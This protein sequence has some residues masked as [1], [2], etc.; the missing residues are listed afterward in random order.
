M[1]R[2][3]WTGTDGQLYAGD[4]HE[5]Q[6]LSWMA[7]DFDVDHLGLVVLPSDLGGPRLFAQA[8]ASPDGR[9][10]AAFSL[11]IVASRSHGR[12]ILRSG[13]SVYVMVEGGV[14]LI[15]VHDLDDAGPVHLSWHPNGRA[16]RILTQKD[17]VLSLLEAS[18]EGTQPPRLLAEGNPLF[19]EGGP[20]GRLI[21]HTNGDY[22]ADKNAR[23]LLLDPLAG[24]TQILCAVPGTFPSAAWSPDFSRVAYA[25]AGDGLESA[26]VVAGT[27]GE[28]LNAIH[29]FPGRACFSW[30]P[31]GGSLFGAFGDDATRHYGELLEIGL[32]GSVQERF[33]GDF[34]AYWTTPSGLVI[35][36]LDRQ[37]D[38]VTFYLSGAA[39]EDAEA[40]FSLLQTQ[41]SRFATHFFDQF[42]RSHPVL[43]GDGR[44][45]V[46]TGHISRG[47]ELDRSDAPQLW[48]YDLQLK[49]DPVAVNSAV[50]GCFAP[51]LEA[52]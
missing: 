4:E 17:N 18:L 31:K 36:G 27:R 9:H 42:R 10:V 21:V 34:L 13:G 23:V 6:R 22:R 32:D 24:T 44:W 2:M 12:P 15:K 25:M 20:D 1:P 40:L 48:L 14:D 50:F 11:P 52:T 33:S 29:T 7:E 19:Y 51:D 37:T 39:G 3:L 46:A 35:L 38:V 26:L 47:L 49:P 28:D 41:E 43:S 16:L 5:E 45:L 30:H 8:T